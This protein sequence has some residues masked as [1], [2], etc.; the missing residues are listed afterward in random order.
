MVTTSTLK[1][2][3]QVVL[4]PQTTAAPP[5]PAEASGSNMALI[6]GAAGVGVFFLVLIAIV[7]ELLTRQSQKQPK[8][9]PPA[10]LT[11]QAADSGL[12]YHREDGSLAL[13]VRVLPPMYTMY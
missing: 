1:T 2:T 4:T 7:G 9:E 6:G 3:T 10:K 5:P 13:R 8:V 11:A 12:M